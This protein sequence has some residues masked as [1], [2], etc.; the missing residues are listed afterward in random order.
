MLDAEGDT[1]CLRDFYMANAH[2]L[3]HFAWNINKC[4]PLDDRALV[5]LIKVFT[6]L[7]NAMNV[8]GGMAGSFCG[9]ST[10]AIPGLL[11]E[12]ALQ[13]PSLAREMTHWAFHTTKN[14]Y[15]PFGT[16]NHCREAARSVSD[17]LT[18]NTT[19]LATNDD[20]DTKRSEKAKELAAKRAADHEDRMGLQ[21]ER[22]QSR[23]EHL[24]RV[25][26]LDPRQ[27]IEDL[28]VRRDC[29]PDYY[30]REWANIDAAM[31][32]SM[33]QQ[34]E[35]VGRLTHAQRG[36]WKMLKRALII[37]LNNPSVDAR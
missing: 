1:A 36:P 5:Q 7:E 25:A 18:L 9:G 11:R 14:P 24:S 35:L 30:P 28:L 37:H 34:I 31:G 27:R 13:N 23:S 16:Y 20:A 10:T 32:L 19:R 22:K 26:R 6:R 29:A 17:Y 3:N 2:D 33:A 12:L 8:K 21:H 4:F 15:V